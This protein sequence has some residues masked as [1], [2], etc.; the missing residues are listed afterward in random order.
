MKGAKVTC[1]DL[2]TG[3]SE[4]KVVEPGDYLF[5]TVEPCHIDG[6]Q[7]YSTGTHVVTVKKGRVSEHARSHKV[8]TP[9]TGK[10]SFP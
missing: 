6:I 2:E 10:V 3:E 5:V 7:T 4:T 1:E 9:D 8:T